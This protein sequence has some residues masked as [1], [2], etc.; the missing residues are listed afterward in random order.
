MDG[1]RTTPPPAS[2]FPTRRATVVNSIALPGRRRSRAVLAALLAVVVAA[3]TAIGAAS[4]QSAK[5]ARIAYMS[6]AVAN[7]YDAPMLAAAKKVA[8]AKNAS[9]TVFDAANDP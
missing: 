2:D 6:F 4:S 8:K 7:S 3:G 5:R 9:V 1:S